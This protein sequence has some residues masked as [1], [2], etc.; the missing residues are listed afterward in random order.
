MD[1]PLLV[2]LD[3]DE[4]LFHSASEP[5]GFSA[6]FRLGAFHTYKRPGVEG[7]LSALLSDSRFAVAV[8]TSAD[9]D[10][11]LAALQALH[12]DP[13]SLVALFSRSHCS[14]QECLEDDH[15]LCG[16]EL[17]KDLRKLRK[18]TG[19][20][21]ERMIAIDDKPRFFQ[22]QYSNLL[23]VTPFEGKEMQP[24]VFPAL[25]AM[26]ETIESMGNVRAVEK[27]GWYSQSRGI[28]CGRE[29]TSPALG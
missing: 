24:R 11:A 9:E 10:Y 18:K 19:W 8:W 15:S 22:R 16:Y 27:R 25:L 4:T 6:H 14:K 7:F 1:R 28:L 12:I 2:V 13:Q 3:L 26:L 20:P 21:L 29:A 17:V 5:L 23:A